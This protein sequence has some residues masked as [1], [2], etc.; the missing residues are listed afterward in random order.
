MAKRYSND[1]K[2]SMVSLVIED[3]KTPEQVCREHQL[4]KSSLYAWLQLFAS[5]GETVFQG[6]NPYRPRQTWA[7]QRIPEKEGEVAA[8][9]RLWSMETRI[10]D[11]E[12]LCGQLALENTLLK[13]DL[14]T[15]QR[16]VL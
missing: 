10:A 7:E 2:R 16:S 13:R 3:K 5:Q 14:A 15:A 4:P 12:R 8:D 9:I 6:I 1:F 11:L